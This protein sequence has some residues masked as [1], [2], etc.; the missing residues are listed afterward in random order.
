M[1]PNGFLIM[2][3]AGSGKST[4][5]MALAQKLAWD[6]FDA[7]EYHSAENIAK[8]TAGIPLTDSDRVPWLVALNQQLLSTLET[9][10]HPILA[11]SA[12][13]DRYRKKLL[14]GLQEMA[15]IYLKGSFEDIQPR[16]IA[17][18]KHYMKEHMLQSQFNTLEEPENA[19]VLD[20]SLTV[21]KMLESIFTKYSLLER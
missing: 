10:R 9:D 19:L 6:F 18:E 15:I 5:G 13:K 20:V 8:M 4:L 16:L 2:G 1:Q 11:C 14:D 7:D 12:L 17:R 3:V 21:S